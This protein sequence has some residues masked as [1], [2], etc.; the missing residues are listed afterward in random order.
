M[1]EVSKL[2]TQL[3]L[4]LKQVTTDE[5]SWVIN[6]NKLATMNCI[7][8]ATAVSY[9]SFMSLLCHVKSNRAQSI[10]KL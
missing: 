5:P 9:V 2:L 3:L 4:S 7:N 8:V 1:V 10:A 6:I